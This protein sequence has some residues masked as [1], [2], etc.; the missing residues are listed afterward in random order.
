MASLEGVE[1]PT[2]LL[3]PLVENAIKHGIAQIP[4]G[5]TLRIAAAAPTTFVEIHV[6]NPIDPDAEKPQGL[7]LG[8]R[9]VKQRLQGRYGTRT[10]FEAKIREERHEVVL[11]FPK[12]LD[13]V[14]A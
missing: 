2:L 11:T 8:L 14:E 13:E 1:I 12:Y 4:E 9:Q 7:G 10:Y 5:G 3:Q 6:E